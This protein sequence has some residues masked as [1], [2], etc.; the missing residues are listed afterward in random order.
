LYA[1]Q[2]RL[3]SKPNE[4]SLHNLSETKYQKLNVLP[5]FTP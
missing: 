5:T 2:T 3:Q 1:N 4:A